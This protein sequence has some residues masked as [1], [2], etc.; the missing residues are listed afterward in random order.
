M[1][2]MD[3]QR[4]AD[5]GILLLILLNVPDKLLPTAVTLLMITTAISAAIKP[6]SMAVA[7]EVSLRKALKIFFMTYPLCGLA[8]TLGP[9]QRQCR[10]NQFSPDTHFAAQAFSHMQNA[11]T[12]PYGHDQGVEM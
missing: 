5:C 1:Q 4:V 2:K 11:L 9:L 8:L 6:Y 7:P 10:S 12:V 3:G